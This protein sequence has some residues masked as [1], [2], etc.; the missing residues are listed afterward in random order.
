M[1][2]Q[3]TEAKGAVQATPPALMTTDDLASYLGVPKATLYRWNYRSSGPK[4]LR[5]GRHVRYRRSDVE[6][7][8][9]TR[10]SS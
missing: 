1:Q 2:N 8:L 4:R 9:T 3:H 7:W 10:V 5:L 6:R